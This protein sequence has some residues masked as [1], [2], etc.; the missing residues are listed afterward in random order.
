MRFPFF[1]LLGWRGMRA[2]IFAAFAI[3]IFLGLK[4]AKYLEAFLSITSLLKAASLSK[5]ICVSA[6]VIPI[7]LM[8]LTMVSAWIPLLLNAI[9]VPNLG[10]SQPVNLPSAINF[11]A[12]LVDLIPANSNFPEYKV[13][14]YFQPK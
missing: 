9:T 3:L 5:L 13:S 14:G 11:F 6:G 4:I 7:S 8:K 10:S 2:I 12:S 1:G